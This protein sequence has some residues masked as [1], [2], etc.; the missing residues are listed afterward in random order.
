ML[1]LNENITQV[2]DSDTLND[3]PIFM[4]KPAGILIWNGAANLF[5]FFVRD[6]FLNLL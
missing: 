5:V 3:I 1:C 2:L 4:W 6:F